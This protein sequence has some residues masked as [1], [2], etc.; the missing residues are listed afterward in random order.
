MACL[1]ELIAQ[2]S[3]AS[4]TRSA[5]VS[6]KKTGATWIKGRDI[7][8]VPKRGCGLFSPHATPKQ[9]HRDTKPQSIPLEG[10]TGINRN[11][12]RLAYSPDA[13]WSESSETKSIKPRI[14]RRESSS[15]LDFQCRPSSCG[16]RQLSRTTS[17]KDLDRTHACRHFLGDMVSGEDHYLGRKGSGLCSPNNVRRSRSVSVHPTSCG[18]AFFSAREGTREGLANKWLFGVSRD[19]DRPCGRRGAGSFSARSGSPRTY[20]G[21]AGRLSTSPRPSGCYGGSPSRFRQPSGDRWIGT[22]AQFDLNKSVSVLDRDGT[23]GSQGVS[24]DSFISSMPPWVAGLRETRVD[25]RRLMRVCASATNAQPPPRVSTAPLASSASSSMSTT[26]EISHGENV[27]QLN[28]M[29]GQLPSPTEPLKVLGRPRERLNTGCSMSTT[30]SISGVLSEGSA[31]SAT[32]LASEQDRASLSGMLSKRAS[33][34][35]GYGSPKSYVQRSYSARHQ[36]PLSAQRG[37]CLATADRS[38]QRFST[39]APGPATFGAQSRFTA[40]PTSSRA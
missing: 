14:M 2:E 8:H 5:G 26:S 39:R 7:E 6:S 15:S 16:P 12:A 23:A 19:V 40:L 30:A 17:E 9:S 1:R 25:I 37:P 3:G 4:D 38:G 18:E 35:Q 24:Q 20:D 21:S 27:A 34:G 33:F 36:R 22:S 28:A 13:P 10:S 29:S 31:A 11:G 32:D